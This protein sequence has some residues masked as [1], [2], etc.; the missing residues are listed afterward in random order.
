MNKA[1]VLDFSLLKEQGLTINDL[2]YLYSL[3]KET[4]ENIHDFMF[5]NVDIKALEEKLYVKII[6]DK[7]YLREKANELIELFLI[8]FKVSLKTKKKIVRKSVR[9]INSEIDN[10][11]DEYRLKWKG[12]KAGS[13]GDLQACKEKLTKWMKDHPE[14]SFDQILK[15]ADL[16]LETEGSNAQYLQRADYFIYK[17]DVNKQNVSRLSAFIDDIDT[18]NEK[19]WTSNLN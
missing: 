4:E 12:L 17:Q 14:Y 7:V 9:K 6:D 8:E 1:L 15:A 5:Q 18:I 3:H 19:D 13:M 10:R 16:Y 2:L 11:I